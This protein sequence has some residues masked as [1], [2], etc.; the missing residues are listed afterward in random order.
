MP[1]GHAVA[2]ALPRAMFT[3]VRPC[4]LAAAKPAGQQGSAAR[5]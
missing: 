2:S 3:N 4:W 1:F 5:A